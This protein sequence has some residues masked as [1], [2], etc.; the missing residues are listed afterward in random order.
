MPCH[1][2]YSGQSC[3][4]D[5]NSVIVINLIKTVKKIIFDTAF[6]FFPILTLFYFKQ[7]PLKQKYNNIKHPPK[8]GCSW[9][10]E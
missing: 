6:Q 5:I 2:C 9:S 1:P 3:D 10:S 8:L 7:R 4:N